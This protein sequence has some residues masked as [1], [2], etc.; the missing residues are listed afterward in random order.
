M[1]LLIYIF[2]F[3]IV[4]NNNSLS[5]DDYFSTDKINDSTTSPEQTVDIELE[6]RIKKVK[7]DTAKMV[8]RYKTY[9]RNTS[10]WLL[11]NDETYGFSFM[12]PAQT[13]VEII[14]DKIQSSYGRIQPL[15][16]YRIVDDVEKIYIGVEFKIYSKDKDFSRRMLGDSTVIVLDHTNNKWR[17]DLRSS[18]NQP[19]F[20]KWACDENKEKIIEKIGKGEFESIQTGDGDAGKAVSVHLINTEK[21]LYSLIFEQSEGVPFIDSDFALEILNTFDIY[22]RNSFISPCRQ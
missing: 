2:V 20:F 16:H 4:N 7:E 10:K 11:Y 3:V 15:R 1:V 5:N 14:D 9:D 12:H 22:D 18:G 6:E 19:E 13:S 17:Y 21:Y 8:S